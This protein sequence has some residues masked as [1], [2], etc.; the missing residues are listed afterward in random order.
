MNDRFCVPYTKQLWIASVWMM[1]QAMQMLPEY[2]ATRKQAGSFWISA[3]TR[4][5][6]VK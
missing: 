2:R 6:P 3:R 5:S 4:N 1:R